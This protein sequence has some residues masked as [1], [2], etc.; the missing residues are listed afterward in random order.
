[1]GLCPLIEIVKLYKPSA[2]LNGTR[3]LLG[4]GGGFGMGPKAFRS[5]SK[6]TA[7]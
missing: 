4:G 2:S 1:M 3:D 5:K 7:Y 6:I